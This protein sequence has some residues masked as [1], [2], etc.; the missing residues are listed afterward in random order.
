MSVYYDR[1]IYKVFHIFQFYL[2]FL[3][4]FLGYYSNIEI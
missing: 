3:F 2:S 4:L 1:E